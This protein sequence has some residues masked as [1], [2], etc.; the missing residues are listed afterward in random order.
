[1]ASFGNP[2]SELAAMLADLLET[3]STQH[4]TCSAWESH[5]LGMAIA[6]VRFGDCE[7]ALNCLADFHRPP[8][9][10]PT[11]RLPRALTLDDLRQAIV[12]VT[13]NAPEAD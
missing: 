9:A 7:C 13:N 5:C 6:A 10:A 2:R 4:R 1:M 12:R 3:Y 8:S 11:F